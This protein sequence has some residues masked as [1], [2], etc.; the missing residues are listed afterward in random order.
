MYRT[1]DL[2]RRRP[3]GALEFLGRI[4]HQVK[5]R[6][7]RIELGEIEARWRGRPGVR[8]AVVVAREDAPGDKRLVA[9]VTAT[10]GS[11]PDAGRC[12]ASAGASSCPTSWCRRSRGRLR[13][14]AADAQ[15]QGRPQAPCPTPQSR[16]VAAAAQ[17]RRP[18]NE[19]EKTIAAIWQEVLGLPAGRHCGQLLRPGRP[20]AAGGAGAAPAARCLRARGLHHR[21]VPL[22]DRPRARRAPGGGN[23]VA[24]AA[25][26]TD[27]LSRAN[28]R[29][30]HDGRVAGDC[31]ATAGA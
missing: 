4:D 8:E 5:I 21:P 18:A 9:Y 29:R 16:A 20:L 25:Q 15:R 30:A 13:R 26:W 10:A 22:P 6:G 24:G 23:G 3:D 27:G 28:A 31:S 7:Y 14:V 11:A 12:C 17:R 1:G 19:L 2:V